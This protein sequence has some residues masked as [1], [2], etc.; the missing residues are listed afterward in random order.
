MKD[1]VT[2]HDL[3]VF[4]KRRVGAMVFGYVVLGN[5]KI[6]VVRKGAETHWEGTR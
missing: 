3:I 6:A 4:A 2:F 5:K 1:D